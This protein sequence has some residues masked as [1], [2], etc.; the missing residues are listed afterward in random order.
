MPAPALESQLSTGHGCWPPTQ[1][2]GPYT[3][4]SFFNGKVIQLL[5][6]TKYSS[7]ACGTV[8][9]PTDGRIVSSASPTF[10]LE[11]KRVARIADSI[12][13]GDTI[14]EGSPNAFLG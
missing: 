7:H 11:G 13:C 2:V 1:A 4:K 5:G 6:H 9:H 10:Y 8:V 3:V 14:A 12:S